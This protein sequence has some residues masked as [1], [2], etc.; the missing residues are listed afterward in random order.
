MN[1]LTNG[2]QEGRGL[3]RQ[4]VRIFKALYLRDSLSQHMK[5]YMIFCM[6]YMFTKNVKKILMVQQIFMGVGLYH[7]IQM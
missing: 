5:I 7:N 1:I 3:M 2:V 6:Y 4:F